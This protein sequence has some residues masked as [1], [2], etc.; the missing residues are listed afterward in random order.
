VGA[1]LLAYLRTRKAPGD[2]RKQVLTWVR[3]DG[4]K[5][6]LPVESNVFALPRLSPTGDRFVVHFGPSRDL[7]TYDFRRRNMTRL[8]SDRMVAFSA[9]A[10]ARDGSR[11]VFATS[12]DGVVGLG[13]VHADGS[14]PVQ[15]LIK[16]LGMRSYERTNPV[17]LPNGNGVI[18]TGLA[19]G[20]TV[21]DLL[22][23]PLT[24]ERRVTVLFQA[25]GVERNAAMAPSGR[26]IAYDSDESRR[27]EVYV[28]P[29]PNA[30]SR[31]WLVSNAGGAGPVWTRDGREI[32]YLDSQRRMMA[33]AVRIDSNGEFHSSTPRGLFT[34]AVD[35]V[36][37]DRGWDV[38]A[39]GERFLFVERDSVA[40]R[41][42]TSLEFVL[43][44][45]WT[46]ELKRL[47]PRQPQ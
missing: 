34:G 21:E 10:W 39:D 28:R 40:E 22:F 16:G 4:R 25:P 18:M 35:S 45:N 31:K 1:G 27:S 36:G 43:I 14:G 15:E 11:V 41:S 9:P 26:F 3:R 2:L 19:P 24:G 38:T 42:Q 20:A 23:V 37:L 6:I 32:V 5:D 33:V 7:W 12:F 30:G 13:S 17:M 29:F 46:E 44:Q 47:V 8:P